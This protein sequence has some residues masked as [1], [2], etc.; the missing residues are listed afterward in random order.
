MVVI[1]C[2]PAARPIPLERPLAVPP[3]LTDTNPDPK[4]VEVTLV[5]VTSTVEYLDGK[6]AA[7]WAYKD[8]ALPDG[9]G[10][11]PGPTLVA[12]V[13]DRV[14]VHFQNRLDNT[15]TTVHWHGIRPP[16]GA[17]GS[18]STQLAVLPGGTSTTSSSP[19]TRGPSGTTPMST[20]TFRSSMASMARSGSTARARPR[21]P[22]IA[23]SSWTTSSS[24]R[25][26]SSRARPTSST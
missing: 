3:V 21:W 8:G 5:A 14:I 23:F 15:P 6:P 11:I 20:K 2:H 4:I 12:N 1:G 7:V 16:N 9:I 10:V 26:A 17:D 18:L 19:R 13:G 25:M 24:T 22:R